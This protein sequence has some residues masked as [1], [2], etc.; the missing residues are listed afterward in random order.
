MH[1]LNTSI[2][3]LLVDAAELDDL[4]GVLLLALLPVQYFGE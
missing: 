2:G 1:K 4:S 3:Q